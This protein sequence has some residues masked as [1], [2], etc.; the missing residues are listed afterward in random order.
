MGVES[1][2]YDVQVISMV[3]DMKTT[4][5]FFGNAAEYI[6]DKNELYFFLKKIFFS[7]SNF[8]NWKNLYKKKREQ[9]IQEYFS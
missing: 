2:I 9:F 3:L 7:K 1:M 6:Y 4:F 5:K 8:M